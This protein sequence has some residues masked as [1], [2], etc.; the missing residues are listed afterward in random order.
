VRKIVNK[1]IGNE[2]SSQNKFVFFF[3]LMMDVTKHLQ[4]LRGNIV[5]LPGNASVL[6]ICQ[7]T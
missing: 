2:L 4:L 7:S 1:K 3:P 6:V 5:D